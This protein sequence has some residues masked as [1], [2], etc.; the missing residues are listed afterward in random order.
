MKIKLNEQD[1]KNI[2]E[3]L[4][5]ELSIITD[6][7]REN[8]G[9]SSVFYKSYA[10]IHVKNV[11]IIMNAANQSLCKKKLRKLYKK[12]HFKIKY[13]KIDL[14]T[15]DL[16]ILRKNMPC[17]ENIYEKSLNNNNNNNTHPLLFNY[18]HDSDL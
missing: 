15:F 9:L 13:G 16:D 12:I 2:L 8:K 3:G 18:Y 7:V 14:A 11:E 10:D 1:F 6:Y 5:N 17:C 4:T